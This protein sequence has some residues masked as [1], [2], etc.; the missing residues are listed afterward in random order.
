MAYGAILGQT[1]TTYTKDQ[2]LS[3]SDAT[4]LGLS[5]TATPANMFNVLSHVGDLHVWR[6]TVGSIIDYPVSTNRD[7]YQE[8]SDAKEAGYTLG[9]VQTGQYF[10]TRVSATLQQC[11]YAVASSVLVNDDGEV[12]LNSPTY[13]IADRTSGNVSQLSTI[14]GKF[15]KL[16][17]VDDGS[18]G[19]FNE[20]TI[21]FIPSD[22]EIGAESTANVP[23]VTKRQTVTGY[24]A[25]PAGTTIE[26]LGNLGDKV[27]IQIVSYVGTGTYGSENKTSVTFDF[28][29]KIIFVYGNTKS[30][31][32]V[33]RAVIF[34]T[35]NGFSTVDGSNQMIDFDNIRAELNGTT[36]AWYSPV[37]TAKNQ[38]NE[39]GAGYE[40]VA[41]G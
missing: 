17:R 30:N 40:A 10:F 14:K 11:T 25:I 39:S 8:G 21:Y 1:N 3:S 2:I 13:V 16:Y 38:L 4:L 34:P 26:Y 35:G 18:S 9:A 32:T 28:A 22:A 31:F 15:I 5:S 7:A 6:R 23:Y 20:N 12:T 37:N 41:F 27:R 24:P 19:N 29:P 33:S 36:V